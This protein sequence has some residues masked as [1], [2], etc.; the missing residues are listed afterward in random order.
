MDF[1]S[2]KRQ[3]K[4]L[5]KQIEE[6]ADD[7]SETKRVVKK[8]RRKKKRT[9]KPSVDVESTILAKLDGYAS[10]GS[11]PQIPNPKDLIEDAIAADLDSSVFSDDGFDP[12]PNVI[13]WC[14]N[15]KYLNSDKDLFAKQI[16]V[17]VH[18]FKD[19]CYF[20]SDAEY[21]HN[22]PVD[23]VPGE[24][25]DRITLLHHGVCPDCKRNRI[26]MLDEWS[27]DPK[28]D[29][30]NSHLEAS[31][32]QKVRPVPPNEFVGV[33]GQRSGKSIT[34]SSFLLT[35]ILHRYLAIPSLARY[36][37]QVENAIFEMAFVAPTMDQANRNLWLPFRHAY[38]SAPWFREVRDHIKDEGKRLGLQL[39]RA[40]LTFILFV[41]KRLSLQMMAGNSATL[42]G[43]TRVGCAVDELGWF[44]SKATMGKG[45]SRDGREV[46]QSLSNSLR[47]VRT[48]ADMYRRKRLRD[49]NSLDG[50]MVNIGSPSSIA[51]PIMERGSVAAVNPRIYYTHF[52]TWDF[53]PNESEELICEEFAGDQERLMRD[54]Y[55]IPPKAVSPFLSEDMHL[56][57]LVSKEE[58]NLFVCEIKKKE[59]LGGDIV[60][61]PVAANVH[62]DV[63]TPR[64]FAVDNGETKNSFAMAVGRYY[65]EHDGVLI[66]NLIEV[67]PHD[68]MRVDL[69]WSY[70]NFI[71]PLIKAFYTHTVCYD[72]WQSSHAIHDLRT[73][74]RVNA[75][76]YSLT[77]K[78]FKN[79]K[80]DLYASRIWFPPLE[81]D[82]EE[83]LKL[84]NLSMRAR[85]PRAHLL[86]QLET[87]NQFGNRVVK[88]DVGNDDLFRT[89]VLLHRCIK[90]DIKTFRKKT[91]I[92][93]R[94]HAGA[95][96][97]VG[98]FSSRGGTVGAG[99][100]LQRRARGAGVRRGGGAYSPS[101]SG[102]SGFGGS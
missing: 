71:V 32:R 50:Y 58:P 10:R 98:I 64:V 7:I 62:G 102:H 61:R 43:G 91:K 70:D 21:I 2:L 13:E 89:V 82:P 42:R 38:D 67:A 86:A 26:E 59:S 100:G 55:G 60:M 72:Q 23:A 81:E 96:G 40:E 18:F 36:Y 19:V 34:V 87:V 88:P 51:D 8:K 30:F 56:K 84:A 52:P 29:Q 6:A 39:Y 57:D 41:N 49:Y 20:C 93:L 31:T 48:Q 24:V 53:N 37:N 11:F 14:R 45:G 63:H 80:E 25:L 95:P 9:Q 66:E 97:T 73:N 33:W 16:E 3:S 78:D 15:P 68:D 46:F 4:K 5:R 99:T 65:P 92:G 76:K 75:E 35:Y 69:A 28:F 77:P 83:I 74:Q 79:F 22:T 90:A 85:S 54:F 17:L 12:A 27:K 47:T 1:N 101:T 94:G 44:N